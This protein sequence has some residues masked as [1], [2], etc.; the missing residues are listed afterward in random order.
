L[1][2]PETSALD[3]GVLVPYWARG[4]ELELEEQ[5]IIA[6]STVEAE[7]I[8]QAHAAR[9]ALWLHT[10]ISELRGEM[11]QPLTTNC[12]NQGAISLS[13]DNKFHA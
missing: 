5:Q 1:G 3:L 2:I 13:K 6:L 10:F 4:S 12:D 8:A 9:E 11:T 7:Y